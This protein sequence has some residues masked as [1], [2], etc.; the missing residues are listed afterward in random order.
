MKKTLFVYSAIVSLL[1]LPI[2]RA[3]ILPTPELPPPVGVYH[4]N[5]EE[6]HAQFG[7]AALLNKAFHRAF[8][9]HYMPPA[10]GVTDTHSFGSLMDL[11]GALN[12]PGM[13]WVPFTATDISTP[14]TVTI[15]GLGMNE[16]SQ[17]ML[18]LDMSIPTP[19]GMLMIRESPTI[20]SMGHTTITPATGGFRIDSF[21]DVYT[22][23]SLDNGMSWIPD[24]NGPIHVFYECPEPTSASLGLLGLGIGYA[25]LIA[26]RRQSRKA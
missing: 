24:N 11:S 7:S 18:A 23:L 5:L 14:T 17:E 19:I 25:R 10:Q 4:A 6:L 12:V 8:T 3:D 21:F 16:Y 13:G 26:R 2:A 20:Q 22:E 15:T 9:D 1:A